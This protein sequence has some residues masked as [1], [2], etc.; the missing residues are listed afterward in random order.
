MEPAD[1][2]LWA[3]LLRL[4]AAMYRKKAA[5]DTLSAAAHNATAAMVE[6]GEAIRASERRE[7]AEHPDL[8]EL[9]ARMDG[10][11]GDGEPRT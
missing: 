7:V 6:F 5:E 11:Y 2:R 8:R 4:R 9:D 1:H 10:F 3:R